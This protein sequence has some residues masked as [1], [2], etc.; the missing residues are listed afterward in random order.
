MTLRINLDRPN[1][2]APEIQSLTCSCRVLLL[3]KDN[4]YQEA[5]LSQYK[6][7]YYFILVKGEFDDLNLFRKFP[8]RSLSGVD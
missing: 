6:V 4:R 3:R 1:V 2:F 8:E 7:M 5:L